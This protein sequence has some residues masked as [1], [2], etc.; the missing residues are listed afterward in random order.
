MNK[1][2]KIDTLSRNEFYKITLQNGMVLGKTSKNIAKQ[3]L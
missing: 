1:Y 3:N 2:S